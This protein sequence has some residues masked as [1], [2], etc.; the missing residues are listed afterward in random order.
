VTVSGIT[1]Y[2]IVNG[3]ATGHWQ[4]VDR[5]DLYQQIRL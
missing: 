1:I 4:V 2:E 5:A 3:L